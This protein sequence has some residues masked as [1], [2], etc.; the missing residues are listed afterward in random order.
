MV[1]KATGAVRLI[2][3]AVV[4][5]WTSACGGGGGGGGG[6]A[7]AGAGPVPS[8][9]VTFAGVSFRV[10]GNETSVPPLENPAGSPPSL[11]APLDTVVL[12]NFSGVPAG[13]FNGGNLAVF[14]TPAQ[15]PPSSK[16]PAG[17]ATVP[18]KGS[19]VT[20]AHTDGTATVEFHPF[21][22]TA[23]LQIDLTAPPA[24]VPGLLPAAIY[25]ALVSD[26]PENKIGNLSGPGGSVSFG[27]TS[28]P[29]AFYPKGGVGTAAPLVVALQPPPFST[30]FKPSTYAGTTPPVVVD[31]FPAGPSFFELS[32]DQALLPTSA[33]LLGEDHTGD[34]V[35]EPTFFVSSRATRLL[36]THEVPAGALGSPGGFLALS[37]VADGP[38]V[39]P[40][41]DG[42]DIVLADGAPGGLG[43]NDALF[44]GK[45]VSLACALD[46]GLVYVALSV[47]GG[48]DRFTVLDQMLGDP[49]FGA[50]AEDGGNT[51]VTLDTG[52]DQLVGLATLPDGRLVGFDRSTKRIYEL[53]PVLTRNQPSPAM[54]FAGAPVLTGLTVGDGA[55]GFASD[56]LLPGGVAPVLDVLD[57]V[58]APSGELQALAIIDGAGT[59][60]LLRLTPI[61]PD[62]DGV[63]LP[64]EGTFSGD[65]DD[66]LLVLAGPYVDLVYDSAQRLLALDPVGDR[67]DVLDPA[68][69]LQDT[70]AFQVGSVGGA[71][72]GGAA[73]AIAVGSMAIDV[74]VSLTANTDAG[75]VVQLHP[76]SVL[77]MGADLH[78]M[79]RNTLASL[80]GV[81]LWN[82]DP[83]NPAHP[84]GARELLT[85][86][87]S[88]PVQVD[89]DAFID[90]VYFEQFSD[91]A[92]ESKVAQN[93][94]PLAAWAEPTSGGVPSGGLRASV[95]G[96]GTGELGDFL[97]QPNGLFNAILTYKRTKIP[98]EAEVDTAV[99]NYR[100]VVLDT[101]S[102][103]FPMA[104]GSTPGTSNSSVVLGGEFAF[105]DFIVPEGVQLVVRGSNPLRV[106]ASGRIEIHGFIDI[107]GQNGLGD[108]TFDSGFLPVP[109]GAGGPAAGRGGD[110]HPTLSDPK[111]PGSINQYV[112]P[113]RGERG[114][115]PVLVGSGVLKLGQ[116]GG[117]GGLTTLGYD[118]SGPGFPK[119]NN[120]D[121]DENHRPPGGGGGSFAVRGQRSHEGA[122]VYLV[123]SSSS[124]FPF[125]KCPT[126]DKISAALYGN[127]ENKVAG[128]LPNAPL[129]CVYM[130]GVPSNPERKKPGA[131][132]GDAVFVDGNPDNDWIGMGGELTV[133]IGGQ[134]GGGGG[135]R[136]DS[137]RH[138]L[139]ALDQLGNPPSPILAPHYPGLFLGVFVS[140]TLLDAKGGGG[141]GGGGAILLRSFEDIIVGKTGRIDASGGHGGGGEV[142]QNSAFAAGGGGGSG[143]AVLLQA[144]GKVHLQAD[145]GHRSANY[146]DADGD[147]GAAIDVSG[148]FGR[149][150]RT[151]SS[152]IAQLQAFTFDSTRSD[153]GQGG[154]GVIQLQVG[155]GTG[156]PQIDEGA[157]AF[158]YQRSNL[159]LGLWTDDLALLQADHLSF[160]GNNG[161]PNSLRY[162]DMLHWRY[163]RPEGPAGNLPRDRYLVL[164]GAYPPLIPS[165]TG[166]NGHVVI[167]EWP[168]GSGQTWFDTAMI[169]SPLSQGRA[170][171]RE[172]EPFKIM[173]TYNGWN[174]AFFEINNPAD[175][176]DFPNTPGTTYKNEKIPFCVEVIE[177]DGRPF[178]VEVNGQQ[179][180][181]PD[182]LIHKLP[183]VHPSLLPP[184][185]GTVSRGTSEWLDFSGAALRTRDASGR[186]P[187]FF[188]ALHGTFNSGVGAVPAGSD[189]VV[190]V[191]SK[192][193]GKPA[194]FVANA[195]ILDPG[196]YP[197]P[198][199][200]AANPPFNDIKVDAPDAGLAQP[201]AITDNAQ[202]RLLFQG[203]HA[204]RPGSH[205]PDPDT[206]TP[207]VADLTQLDGHAL[208]RF[209]VEFDLGVDTSGFP[210][211]PQSLRP[212]VDWV[213]L[214][215][216]Y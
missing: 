66:L 43:A 29:A 49:R 53:L 146:R 190:V 216:R 148:G 157:H 87:T 90:D 44:D 58:V 17:S 13:P 165:P 197:S 117:H 60:A 37:A 9:Q 145:P 80:A 207:W 94:S 184:P 92:F 119:V 75:A 187:P 38:G 5:A 164:N 203:A 105:R 150:A 41:V 64:G 78:V 106:T 149:D 118:P 186:T 194:H 137:M 163:F 154:F 7:N 159:K 180:F 25:T 174:Q 183:V 97:P 109:G 140:P 23:P 83:E 120:S 36:V 171:V 10:G 98:P 128:V 72:P 11:G 42:S 96:G 55:T 6:G 82:A 19:F 4:L 99:A 192:V 141:G 63:S 111:G 45:P 70:V 104:D 116:V 125:T 12:F 65:A 81:S 214:R 191:A 16:P 188:G 172:P 84:L 28:N 208:V 95:G 57:L 176:P 173:K 86:S 21:I 52:L 33:N 215:T 185:I 169:V 151:A 108:D 131:E 166:D 40:E 103:S 48:S 153:G 3:V 101:D 132:P 162:I 73:F 47:D 107:A 161:L 179:V 200:G 88:L 61:D 39:V 210:Y 205:V 175:H 76:L 134:G 170:V 155:D 202:V 69:G 138:N 67:V 110:G 158:A 30:N 50:Q 74:D 100:V 91:K 2:V 112:T 79:Q 56:P 181:D 102:Q 14:S 167:N 177:P 142:V 51:L 124:W 206:L 68:A 31:Q 152:D 127:E 213:R 113:E 15:L 114:W 193:P 54:P 1:N 32:F 62:G 35:L 126:N 135:S 122:G 209:R 46:P 34:G 144:A 121:N 59:R 129:Q 136:I 130:D 189:G 147:M 212:Q 182:R 22:P 201:D 93:E 178:T 115:G 133:L 143:G 160:S 211:S 204:V 198:P 18:A 139:W 27:T 168:E 24:A 20:V 71:A 123:Q 77:P 199:V 8:N 196:L 195:G 156:L 26:S 89:P 85:V